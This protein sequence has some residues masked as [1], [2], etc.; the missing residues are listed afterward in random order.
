MIKKLAPH[1][2]QYKGYAILAPIC[3]VLEVL[4]EVV[5]PFI[6]TKLVDNGIAVQDMQVVIKYGITMI[7][8]AILGLGF[9]LL[10]A[11][12]TVVASMGFA[13]NLRENMFRKV[14]NYS[15]NN[16]DK[17]STGSLITRFTTDVGFVQ[18][19]FSVLV[20][21]A[22]RAP[23]MLSLSVVMI[24]F[25]NKTM[26]LIFLIAI[27]VVWG[28]VSL[29]AKIV[30]PLFEKLFKKFDNLNNKVE[31]NLSAI[32]V[33]KS[34]VREDHETES[35]RHAAEDLKNAQ[36]K[37]E[38]LL[39]YANPAM[40]LLTY[41]ITILVV[42]LGGIRIMKGEMS[43]GGISGT[44]G[45]IGQ[46]L[47]SLIMVAMVFVSLF[48]SRASAKRVIE[49]LDEVP[50]I[51]DDE[52]NS[53][54]KVKEG[55]VSFENVSFKYKADAENDVLSDINFEILPGETV[56]IVGGTGSGKSSIVQLIPRLYD[57]TSGSIKVGGIDVREYKLDE[58]RQAVG[59]V[60]QKNTLFSGTIEDNLRWGD[61]DATQEEMEHVCKIASAHD[62]ITSFPDGY[63]SNVT[64]EG[65][66]LSGGQ[67]QRLCIARALLK[68]PKILILDDSTHAV[69][70]TTEKAIRDAIKKDV[71][72]TTLI[73]IAQ[74][75][76]SVVDA[77]KIIVI[78]DGKINGIGTH[79]ELMKTNEIYREIY[80]SQQGGVI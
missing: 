58:L 70:A 34:F 57:T 65:T 73:I 11:R 5:I 51:R 46:F 12:F 28:V 29:V 20:R 54:L 26:A 7:A 21:I 41:M 63:K 17:F 4:C 79:K 55:S 1:V 64:Q 56:G 35:F 16:V 15:Y 37:A 78:D 2:K 66:N 80:S 75:I 52:A 50:D 14:Q 59:M 47:T 3:V 13:A 49:V 38:K 76:A 53:D 24:F 69:D 6:M 77:D 19:A 33:V 31:E 18:M 67:K 71:T 61:M 10:S 62:F 48:M 9:G 27:P 40:N 30:V 60:L 43:I 8:L 23:V 22:F 45:Y 39:V 68:K 36:V 32:R 44:I 74:R 25:I 42:W 72:G